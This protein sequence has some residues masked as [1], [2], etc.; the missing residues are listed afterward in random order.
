MYRITVKLGDK[1]EVLEFESLKKAKLYR[2]YHFEFGN[3]KDHSRWI[4]EKKITPEERRYAI[5]EVTELVNGKI[6]RSY[7]I[8]K[9]MDI[10]L[11]EATDHKTKLD[12]WLDFR[13]ARNLLL[14]K[15]DWTQLAD[16]KL[17][18]EEKLQ[19]RSYREYLRN[20]TSLYDDSTVVN[21]KVY[22]LEEWKSGKR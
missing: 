4:K 16:C 13:Q 7:L 3:W 21:A 14:Q 9:G 20:A 8:A 6:E 12:L 5:D 10:V 22:T 18:Q 2:D 11:E 19:Y 15:T 17:S 1:E